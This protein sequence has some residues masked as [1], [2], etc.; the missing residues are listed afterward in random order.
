[1]KVLFCDEMI[2]ASVIS[3]FGKYDFHVSMRKDGPSIWYTGAWDG[4]EWSA[5]FKDVGQ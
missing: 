1:M 3:V 5:S 2:V 4:A